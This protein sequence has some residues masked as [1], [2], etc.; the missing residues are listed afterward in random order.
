MSFR[1]VSS[2]VLTQHLKIILYVQV[3]GYCGSLYGC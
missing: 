3:S 1:P 2:D